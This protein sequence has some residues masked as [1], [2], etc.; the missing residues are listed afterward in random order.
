MYYIDLFSIFLNQSSL[1]LLFLM[2]NAQ[3]FILSLTLLGQLEVPGDVIDLRSRCYRYPQFGQ[4]YTSQT[5]N[6]QEQFS[7]IT[8]SLS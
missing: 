4:K 8:R 3:I 2:S 6:H 5:T 7:E 1:F